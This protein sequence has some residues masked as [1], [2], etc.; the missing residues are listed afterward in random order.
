MKRIVW[1]EPERVARWVEKRVI[2]TGKFEGYSAIGLENDGELVAGVVYDYHTGPSVNASI[3]SDGSR[4][5]LNPA[6]LAAIFC[7]PFRQLGCNRITVFVRTDNH[8]SQ[9]FVTHLGFKQEGRLRAACA[10]GSDVI[11][12]GILKDECRFIEGKYYAALAS[13]LPRSPLDRV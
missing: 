5:W 11:V 8:D 6:Y 2:E 9:R 10:D 13:R 12:Y 4:R 1:G 7:Y 3:A